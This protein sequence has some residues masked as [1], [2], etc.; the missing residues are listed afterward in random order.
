[1]PNRLLNQRLSLTKLLRGNGRVVSC[2]TESQSSEG[3]G[4][5]LHEQSKFWIG[6]LLGAVGLYGIYLGFSR[7]ETLGA[8][9]SLILVLISIV[10]MDSG[11]ILIFAS[12]GIW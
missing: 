5:R 8:A 9:R 1:L 2:G 10:V 6:L 7:I 4:K 3:G 12:R 11:E